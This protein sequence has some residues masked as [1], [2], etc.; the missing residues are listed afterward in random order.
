MAPNDSGD[1]R[2]GAAED[3]S[4][5]PA[6]TSMAAHIIYDEQECPNSPVT[7]PGSTFGRFK[8]YA[9]RRKAF[10]D[11][12]GHSATDSSASEYFESLA[13]SSPRTHTVAGTESIVHGDENFRVRPTSSSARR[14]RTR[15]ASSMA[16][17]QDIDESNLST[18][19]P[20]FQLQEGLSEARVS[21]GH[22]RRHYIERTEI[23]FTRVRPT[24]PARFRTMGSLERATTLA[25]TTV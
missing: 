25:R 7:L 18:T 8:R 17:M 14:P 24:A 13:P 4:E 1:R 20:E 16:F 3:C 15:T 9:P 11:T 10:F 22:R 12:P 5:P 6:P 21:Q 2:S 23:L 19:E